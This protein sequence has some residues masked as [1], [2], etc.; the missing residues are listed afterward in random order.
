[1]HT[2]LEGLGTVPISQASTQTPAALWYLGQQF[3][4]QTPTST[5]HQ[6]YNSQREGNNF[7]GFGGQEGN[8]A[9]E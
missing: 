3:L 5:G 7:V 6:E 2:P 9:G 8:T 1:M 4:Q